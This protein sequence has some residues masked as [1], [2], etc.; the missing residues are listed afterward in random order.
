MSLVDLSLNRLF[1]SVESILLSFFINAVSGININV[2][3]GW[4]L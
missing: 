1:G 4:T 2:N 3:V